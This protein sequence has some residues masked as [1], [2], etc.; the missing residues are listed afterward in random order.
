MRLMGP[1]FCLSEARGTSMGPGICSRSESYDQLSRGIC[2][3]RFTEMPLCVCVAGGEA[4]DRGW[5]GRAVAG[6]GGE[7][8]RQACSGA[9]QLRDARP[10]T[11]QCPISYS[12]SACLCW[13]QICC[14]GRAFDGSTRRLTSSDMHLLP[15]EGQCSSTSSLTSRSTVVFTRVQHA[16]ADPAQL[17]DANESAIHAAAR[18]GTSTHYPPHMQLGLTKSIVQP[19][20]HRVPR[21]GFPTERIWFM[22]DSRLLCMLLCVW[23][24]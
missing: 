12:L 10:V 11:G 22:V 21:S 14:L 6:R 1:H 13:C 8:L 9:R 3:T 23:G 15:T 5:G 4:A 19:L 16:E 20:D 17:D 2:W 7:L 24:L 18:L